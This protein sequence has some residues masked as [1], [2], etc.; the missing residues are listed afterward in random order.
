MK[1]S[2]NP[3]FSGQCFAMQI[4]WL[5]EKLASQVAILVLVD[6]VLQYKKLQRFHIFQQ[7]RNPCFSGQCFAIKVILEEV[8]PRF[9]SQSLFQWTVFC[10]LRIRLMKSYQRMGRNPC[11]SG[12]C[13]AIEKNKNNQLSNERSQSLFQWTVFCNKDNRFFPIAPIKV[14]TL[15]LVDSV[16]QQPRKMP[17]IGLKIRNIAWI[18][19]A[20][21]QVI[22]YN[23]YLYSI[24]QLI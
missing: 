4:I 14:A 2:R 17:E 18:L 3:C 1:K 6:S 5:V 13:F 15:V 21:V 24:A 8:D 20:F 10:N 19:G 22:K 16:L 11:F 12:Q 9:V 7:S 23:S